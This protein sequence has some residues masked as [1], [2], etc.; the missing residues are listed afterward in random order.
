MAVCCR[1]SISHTVS[2]PVHLAGELEYSSLM[3]GLLDS[4]AGR[5]GLQENLLSCFFVFVFFFVIL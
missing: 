5:L 3:S 1:V 2:H 4:T